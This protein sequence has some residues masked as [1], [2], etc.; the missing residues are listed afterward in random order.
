M[1]LIKRDR[2]EATKLQSYKETKFNQAQRHK[3]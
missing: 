2:F 1:I 3:V